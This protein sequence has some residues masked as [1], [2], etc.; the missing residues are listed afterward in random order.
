MVIPI[1]I[2]A[3]ILILMAVVSLCVAA[4]VGDQQQRSVAPAEPAWEFPQPAL[5][6]RTNAEDE[7]E[8]ASQPDGA[9]VRSAA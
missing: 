1:I 8:A 3:W 4:R 6:V 5:V 9:L 2:C 7:L